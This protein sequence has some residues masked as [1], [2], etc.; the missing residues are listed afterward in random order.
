M[1]SR[2]DKF[3]GFSSTSI[4]HCFEYNH[5]ITPLNKSRNLCKGGLFP[6]KVWEIKTKLV[7]NDEE[8]V[9]RIS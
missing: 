9:P 2:V 3:T 8:V 7:N 1:Q 5:W 6:D 4:Q